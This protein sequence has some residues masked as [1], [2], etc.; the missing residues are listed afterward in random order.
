MLRI[1]GELKAA[2]TLLN[3][4]ILE[5]RDNFYQLVIISR[6]YYFALAFEDAN[7][8]KEGYDS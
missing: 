2:F 4:K 6:L 7:D 1:I 8:C 5:L 3:I